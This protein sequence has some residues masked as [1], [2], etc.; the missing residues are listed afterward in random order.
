MT[1]RRR[2]TLPV[3]VSI[4][5][6]LGTAAP[7]WAGDLALNRPASA[8][9]TERDLPQYAPARANDGDSSTR[10]SSAYADNEWWEVDL[11]SDRTINRVELNWHDAYAA[12]YRIRTRTS[13]SNAWSIAARVSIDSPGLRVHTFAARS[14]RYVRIRGDARATPYGISLWDARVCD[15]DSCAAPAPTPTP[16]PNPTP[17]PTPQLTLQAVDG[18]LG[19]Y[20]LFANPLPT[21]PSYFP[22]A[23]WGS[24][25]HTTA[26][27][28]LD[29]AAGIN[30]YVWAADN[31]FLDDIRADGRFRVIQAQ[32]NRTN[33]GSETAGWLLQDEIDMK[34]GPSA[35][36]TALDQIVNGLP[37]DGRLRYSNYAKGVLLWQ[38]EAQAGCFVNYPRQE[39]AS[40]DLYWMTDPN[41]LGNPNGGRCMP[42]QPD[43]LGMMGEPW[44]PEGE[45]LLRVSEIQRPAN[46]GYQ[47]DYMRRLDARDGV[48]RPI[49]NFV[50]TG[51]PFMES[52]AQGARAIRPQELRAAVWHSIIA[53]ARGILYFQHSFGGPCSGDHHTT[54]TNCEGTR[55]IVA[56]VNAQI[57]QLAT[58]LNSPTV[59]SGVTVSSGIRALAKW[60]GT[61][62]YVFAAARNG[63]TTGTVS[64]PCVGNATAT[65]LGE[66]G[67]VPITGGSLSDGFADKNAVH[68]YRIDGGSRCGL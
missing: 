10:W 2:I 30:T 48:R 55:P 13:G 57:D 32:G 51:W 53:G 37:V 61:N 9:S 29:A 46:Y 41:Q 64:I 4:S 42:T 33:V 27:R 8:S 16:T 63:A 44:L 49:W 12:R 54:R 31:S 38:T 67:S 5:V 34:Q 3:L 60:N 11:G 52:A 45:R 15:N 23:V 28:D 6:A 26:N 65:R 18:G 25:G 17:T 40:S 36:P 56:S 43:C 59:S 1:D 68:I 19:Y 20:G 58:V 50:E 39:L 35:C 66:A 22:R 14:A 21:S 62:F 47:V 7:A 24:Y